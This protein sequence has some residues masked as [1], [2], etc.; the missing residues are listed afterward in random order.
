MQIMLVKLYVEIFKKEIFDEY[1][2]VTFEGHNFKAVSCWDEVLRA[3][4][5]NYMELPS[6]DNRIQHSVN[7]TF[8]YWK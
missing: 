6:E 2:E 7:H 4:Y 3:T 5:G 1:V 8:F